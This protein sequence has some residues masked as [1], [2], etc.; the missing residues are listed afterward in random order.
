MHQL[1]VST[2]EF[3]STRPAN[4]EVATEAAIPAWVNR[5]GLSELMVL[6]D[7]AAKKDPR[8]VK[9]KINRIRVAQIWIGA[10]SAASAPPT[11][12]WLRVSWGRSA[13]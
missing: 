11:Q 1:C 9:P 10:D 13:W 7:R 5:Y 3:W 6:Q 12:R 2:V 8:T 4:Q